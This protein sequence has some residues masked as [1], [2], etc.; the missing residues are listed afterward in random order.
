MN[1]TRF[2]H[3]C[4]NISDMDKSL[5]FYRDGMGF[6]VLYELTY[7]DVLARV[8]ADAGNLPPDVDEGA[9]RFLTANQHNPWSVYLK[10][11]PA[12]FLE[13]F[14]APPGAEPITDLAR[15]VA[16]QHF[17]LEVE[18]VDTAY[19]EL[20]ANGITPESTPRVGPDNAKQ[21]WI[22]DPDGNRVEIMQYTPES[23]HILNGG[24]EIA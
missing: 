1:V 23:L 21:F 19:A 2:A 6:T 12:Q 5:D 13:L 4:F 15:R 24:I 7:G 17:C 22:V 11:A 20:V 14:Y 18:D 8:K 16:F 10:V 9:I 3:V